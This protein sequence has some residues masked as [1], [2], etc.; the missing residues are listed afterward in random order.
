MVAGRGAGLETHGV[1]TLVTWSSRKPRKRR[2]ARLPW[3]LGCRQCCWVF[4][5]DATY[6]NYQEANRAFYRLTVLPLATRVAAAILSELA[7]G[8]YR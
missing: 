4:Q 3:P 5:G 6:A 2:R 1:L 8:L 7:V